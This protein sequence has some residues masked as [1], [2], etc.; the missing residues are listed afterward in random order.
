MPQLTSSDLL[1]HQEILRELY[2]HA[3]PGDF[4]GRVARLLPKLIRAEFNGSTDMNYGAGSFQA[5]REPALNPNEQ[6]DLNARF[7]AHADEHPLSASKEEVLRGVSL[8]TSESIGRSRFIKGALYNEFYRSVSVR[9]ELAMS[10]PVSGN[11]ALCFFMWRKDRSFDP[12]D[13]ARLELLRPH[14]L[15]AYRNAEC[16]ARA[17]GDTGLLDDVG[18]ALARGLVALDV[19]GRVRDWSER[20]RQL[21]GDYF[22][23]WPIGAH[24][25]PDPLERWVRE[26]CAGRPE[27]GKTRE[28]FRVESAAGCLSVRL[29]NRLHSPGF[30]LV[31]EEQKR[32]SGPESLRMLGL[33]A[34]ESVVVWWVAQGKTNPEIATILGANVLTIKKHVLNIFAK[35]GVETRTAAALRVAECR[36]QAG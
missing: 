23:S 22:P 10:V 20:S 15:Q 5:T 11:R 29:I 35:L 33:T 17:Q 24:Q 9:D 16:F 31:F 28:A 19:S 32:V 12:H 25:L 13:L 21:A 1:A 3:P 36:M 26:H 18:E 2:T 30:L 14:V 8:I 4:P 34:R 7:L 6:S 27:A